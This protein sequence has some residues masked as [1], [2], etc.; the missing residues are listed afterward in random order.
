MYIKCSGA[1]V[2]VFDKYLHWPSVSVSVK[3]KN[4]L[5]QDK[6]RCK[7]IEHVT[8]SDLHLYWIYTTYIWL[9][10]R[11][12]IT[13]VRTSILFLLQSTHH[14]ITQTTQFAGV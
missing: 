6:C 1:K 2:S 12:C 10:T 14:Q 8:V 9:L 13:L 4:T 11:T 7:K 3:K 5:Q